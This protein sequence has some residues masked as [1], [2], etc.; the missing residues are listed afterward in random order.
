MIRRMS[1][2]DD[3]MTSMDLLILPA[4]IRCHDGPIKALTSAHLDPAFI[5][6]GGADALVR[7]FNTRTGN[8]VAQLTG[9]RSIITFVLFSAYDNR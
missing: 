9:H 5:A 8:C 1:V 2:L 3:L 6:T 7:V 4:R